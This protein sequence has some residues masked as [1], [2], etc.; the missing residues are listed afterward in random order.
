MDTLRLDIRTR[1]R[2]FTLSLALE[3][4][5]ETVALAGPSG[6]GKST[7]LRAVA[8]LVRPDA[9]SVVLGET[10]L[11]DAVQAIDL[12]PEQRGIGMVFQD[13][14]LFPHL[15]VRRNV[16]FGG[17]DRVDELLDRLRIR[18]LAAERPYV[19]SGGERQRVALA[20]ALA[21]GPRVLLLDEP[22]SALDAHT[23][24]VVRGEL[25]EL[26]SE[27]R[28]PTILVTHDF[29]DAA[30]LADRVGVIVD[31]T[32]RQ[33]GTPRELVDRPADAFV[34]AFTGSVLLRGVAETAGARAR[35][36][37]D[38]GTTL[39]GDVSAVGP[40]AVAVHP[41][42]VVLTGSP[43]AP[44][45]NAIRGRVG[46]VTPVGDRARVRVGALLAEVP[47]TDAPARGDE[48]WATFAV[49]AT[50]VLAGG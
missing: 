48:V 12:P 17:S 1:L 37:L 45:R 18:H 4:G 21:R 24:Q 38:D 15:T 28:L 36:V 8:G 50:R 6:A 34:A 39:H 40:V 14:A 23:R 47:A 31:G 27:L 46:A 43:P 49:D 22:L 35:I 41:W 33:V 9:G 30:A 5:A 11:F 10:T 19:L 7:V 42:D 32:L 2:S 44:D 13:Y 26:L 29:D 20:R 16:A 3:I 25:Q